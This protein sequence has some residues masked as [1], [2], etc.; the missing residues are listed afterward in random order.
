[1]KLPD[2]FIAGARDTSRAVCADRPP[3]QP[4]P[5]AASDRPTV[6]H[7]ERT[8]INRVNVRIILVIRFFRII[9]IIRVLT[10]WAQLAKR[11]WNHWK[12]E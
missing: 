11:S 9:R 7:R 2:A 10:G 8:A 6:T 5:T 1:V 12:H 3:A 4:P